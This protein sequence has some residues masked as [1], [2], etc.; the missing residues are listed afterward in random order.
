MGSRMSRT[1]IYWIAVI[2]YII[3]ATFYLGCFIHSRNTRW[4]CQAPSVFLFTMIIKH[5]LSLGVIVLWANAHLT[6]IE[7]VPYGNGTLNNSPLT[8][9]GSDF[10]CKL[11]PNAFKISGEATYRIRDD[12]V[13]KLKGSATH[14]GGSC[15]ISL[16]KDRVPTKDSEWKVIK[17]FEGGCP[18]NV[19][20]QLARGAD[21]D[22]SLHLPF[23]IPKGIDP[24]KYILA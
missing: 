16:T 12:Q 24:R 18:A 11:R 23:R 5:Y 9:D 6:V 14:G 17:S 15:Q 20:G 1:D 8:I 10:P 13:L 4:V 7:P 2:S 19:A 22:N 21:S 3:E